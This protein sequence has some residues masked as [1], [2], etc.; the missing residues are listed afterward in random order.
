MFI[1]YGGVV[2]RP[3]VKD[4]A[5]WFVY[6][7]GELLSSMKRYKIAMVG[8]GA[9]ACAAVR[10]VGQSVMTDDP[11][12]AFDDE[13]RTQSLTNIQVWL[14][15]S[16]SPPHIKSLKHEFMTSQCVFGI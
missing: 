12:N 11:A 13:V 15:F 3:A 2:V 1:G 9:W 14:V 5:E 10:M 8:S 16:R 6:S 4:G 7:H